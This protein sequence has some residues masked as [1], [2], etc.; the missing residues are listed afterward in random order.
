MLC[1][2]EES[3][4]IREVVFRRGSAVLSGIG[5]CVGRSC[6]VHQMPHRFCMIYALVT[7]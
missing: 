5:L 6:T 4:L 1:S 2:T 7:C 3:G